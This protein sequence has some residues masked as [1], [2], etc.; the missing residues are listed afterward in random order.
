MLLKPLAINY[1]LSE[2]ITATKEHLSQVRNKT[3]DE[4]RKHNHTALV[5][6]AVRMGCL[7]NFA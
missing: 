2:H 5:T 1:L 4:N 7:A 6:L 3:N